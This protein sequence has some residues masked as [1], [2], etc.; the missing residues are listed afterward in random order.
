[1]RKVDQHTISD[2]IYELS[3]ESWDTIFN[4][5]DVNLMFNSFLNTHLRI[6]YSCFP[7]IGIKNISN[8]ISWITLG[9]KTSCKCKRELFLL[10]RNSNNPSLKRYYKTYCR[11]LAKVIK[12]AKRLSYNSRI[13]KSNNKVKTTWNIINELLR[14]QHSTNVIQKLSTEGSLLTNQYDI[15]EA[16]NKY[17]SSIIDIIN[18]NNLDNP[19]YNTSSTYNY[20]DLENGNHHP[21]MVFKSF[22][23]QEIIS[24]SE[25]A[26]VPQ[27]STSPQ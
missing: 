10:N 22:S 6:F 16:V 18:R 4:N 24:I 14:K 23:T 3:N 5:T 13:L 21:P 11:I 26:A 12:E 15:A 9:I 7:V 8:T 25:A 1:V 20:L 19:R 17:F 27:K 2:F